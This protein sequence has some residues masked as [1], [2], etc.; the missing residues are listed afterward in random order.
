MHD[1][2]GERHF[3]GRSLPIV[4]IV[5]KG[6]KGHLPEILHVE[7]VNQ[8]KPLIPDGRQVVFLGDGE[9]DGID[10]QETVNEFGWKYVCRTGINIK[11]IWNG[12]EISCGEALPHIKPDYYMDFDNILFTNAK[13]G[14]GRVICYWRPG[15]ENPIFLVTNMKSVEEACALYSLRFRIETFFSDQKSRGF[16][17][18]KSHISD[19]ERLSRL[20][21]AA[22]LAYIWIIFLGVTAKGKWVGIIHR[23][24]RC[25]LSLFQLGLR[26]LDHFMNEG[27]RIPVAFQV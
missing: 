12:A 16:N 19:P 4:W 22:C 3:Q 10:L 27:K 23:T 15:C 21:I 25:D 9:F 1:P 24:T 5:V 17:L 6:K 14:P 20:L 2:H 18:H 26:L 7:L 8:L 13:Y 11:M